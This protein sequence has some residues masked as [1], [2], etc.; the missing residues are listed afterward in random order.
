MYGYYRQV[1]GSPYP[2]TTMTYRYFVF[3]NTID[4]A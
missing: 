2:R 3:H 1:D 4:S